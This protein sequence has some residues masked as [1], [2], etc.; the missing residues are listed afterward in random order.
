MKP[1]AKF[2]DGHIATSYRNVTATHGWR[3]TGTLANGKP[4]SVGGF[5]T[6][7]DERALKEMQNA[8]RHLMTDGA[9]MLFGEVVPVAMTREE[10]L[11]EIKALEK[12]YGRRFLKKSL[13]AAGLRWRD[14]TAPN[15]AERF[16]VVRGEA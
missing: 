14:L 6:V 11:S 3:A 15:A 5:S 13:H 7:S 1:M 2:S 16:D 9:I 12:Q 8:T 4:W 10:R